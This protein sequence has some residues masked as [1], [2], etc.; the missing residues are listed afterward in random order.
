M[1]A[2]T[3]RISSL[4]F[5]APVWLHALHHDTDENRTLE[6]TVTTARQLTGARRVSLL[7]PSPD[8]AALSVAAASGMDAR[9]AARVRVRLGKPVA[10]IVALNRQPVLT[11]TPTM[12]QHQRSR[13]Y[14]T[15]SFISVPVPLDHDAC[16]VLSVAD[17]LCPGGFQPD[18]V[19]ELEKLVQQVI[20]D[21]RF[22]HI[23]R[24]AGEL[25]RTVQ[26]LRR[27]VIEVQEAERQRIARDLHDEAG[28]VLTSAVL[29]LDLEMM[30]LAEGSAVEA[31]RQVREQLVECSG[32]LHTIAFDLRPRILE[33]LGLHAALRS[34]ASQMME[35]S[36]LNVE[37]TVQGSA[38]ELD[39]IE[40]LVV[41]R[42]VQEALTNVR[43]HA[44][45][46]EVKVGLHYGADGIMLQIADDGI[47]IQARTGARIPVE[48][49]VS[50]GIDGMRERVEQVGGKLSIRR[51]RTGGTCITAHLPG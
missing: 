48:G 6:H 35:I 23:T 42:I 24:W 46:S 9:L 37:I 26:G 7:L 36:G 44:Q 51:G 18:D 2:S 34:V 22:L 45:A 10:G 47:G 13:G 3:S 40:E 43:K 16:G 28:H 17:P 15:G 32:K 30:Q 20:Q 29:R 50:I 19:Q 1:R 8:N 12:T 38:W 25:E 21:L 31:L 27:R 33:D 41:L 5:S 4:E 49:R 14:H 39:Q 11:N